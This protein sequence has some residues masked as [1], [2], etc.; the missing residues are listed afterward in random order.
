M[1]YLCIIHLESAELHLFIYCE[2]C[3]EIV[4]VSSGDLQREKVN[5]EVHELS[6]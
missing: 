6:S 1:E 4:T 2:M 3:D 5:G